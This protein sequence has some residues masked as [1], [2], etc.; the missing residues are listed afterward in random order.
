MFQSTPPRGANCGACILALITGFN[1]RHRVRATHESTLLKWSYVFQSTPPREGRPLARAWA[2]SMRQFQSTSS[3]RGG[4]D[5]RTDSA[6]NAR[7]LIL[8]YQR[9]W[10]MLQRG[11]WEYWASVF[12]CA[13]RVRRDA[14]SLASLL[15]F[16][17]SPP[18]TD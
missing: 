5:T 17:L 13:A 15:Q 18:M 7:T 2:S 11:G 9:T 4:R 6:A 1:P 14:A 12:P 10:A 8:S 16:S 3:A